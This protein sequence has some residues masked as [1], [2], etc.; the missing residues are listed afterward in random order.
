MCCLACAVGCALVFDFRTPFIFLVCNRFA[1]LFISYTCSRDD[2]IPQLKW[3]S[4]QASSIMHRVTFVFKCLN[5]DGQ[6]FFR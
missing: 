4:L 3:N 1:K 6:L 2:L 5:C